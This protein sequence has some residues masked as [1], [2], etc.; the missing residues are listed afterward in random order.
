MGFR[1]V[2]WLLMMFI[3]TFS[4]SH[5]HRGL[6][7]IDCDWFDDIEWVRMNGSCLL[8][9]EN[10]FDNLLFLSFLQWWK[11]TRNEMKFQLHSFCFSFL[12]ILQIVSN[13]RKTKL[14][15]ILFGLWF[16]KAWFWSNWSKW[17]KS[18]PHLQSMFWICFVFFLLFDLRFVERSNMERDLKSAYSQQLVKFEKARMKRVIFSH[19]SNWMKLPRDWIGW[20]VEIGWNQ[21]N[22]DF[23]NDRTRFSF[24]FFFQRVREMRFS[25]VLQHIRHSSN[26]RFESRS[27]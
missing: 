27:I 23:D 11:Q 5:S 16:E 19:L 15:V 3:F 7:V 13:S 4:S 22:N 26:D 10:E 18:Q 20:M 17:L 24:F 8:K 12:Q 9:D 25:L 21:T 1:F 14:I 6:I 2:R